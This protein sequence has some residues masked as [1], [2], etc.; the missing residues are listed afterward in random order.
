[1]KKPPKG[2]VPNSSTIL[3]FEI[4]RLPAKEESGVAATDLADYLQNNVE[5]LK[6]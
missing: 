1:M 3:S 5:L 2:S 6:S 4:K